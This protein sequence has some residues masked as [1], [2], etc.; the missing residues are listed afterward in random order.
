V[1]S[2]GNVAHLLA[3]LLLLGCV[4][5]PTLS[6]PPDYG[7]DTLTSH[8]FRNS[9]WDVISTTGTLYSRDDLFSFRADADAPGAGEDLLVDMPDRLGEGV[10]WEIIGRTGTTP[11]NYELQIRAQGWISRAV[12][13]CPRMPRWRLIFIRDLEAIRVQQ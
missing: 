13:A 3:G 9:E 4:R 10:A 11:E 8:C 1:S 2:T 5:A 12:S 7:P 6:G